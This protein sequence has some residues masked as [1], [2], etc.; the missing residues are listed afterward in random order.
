MSGIV[1]W[2]THWLSPRALEFLQRRQ[3]PPRVL[4][5]ADGAL[6]FEVN[7]S[8][9]TGSLP[10]G[11]SFFDAATRLEHIAQAGIAHQ[12]ISW[13]T[14]LGV[15]PVLTPVEAHELFGSYNDDLATLVRQHPQQLSGLAALTTSDIA[16]SAR[17]L[18]RAHNQLGLIGAVLP[19]GAFLNL[20]GARQLTPIFEVAQRLGS[21]IYLHTGLAHPSI[22]GQWAHPPACDSAKARWLLES[23]SQ[24]AAAWITLGLSDFL[25]AYPDV[26]VQLAM[27]GGVLPAL[28]GS[29]SES[30][31]PQTGVRK[32]YIDSAIIGTDPDTLALAIRH[33]GAERILFGSDYPLQSS[34]QVLQ[35]LRS[36]PRNGASLD[37]LLGSGQQLLDTLHA[38][39]SA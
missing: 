7:S 11:P 1:D 24:F 38:R 33:L 36:D 2:H 35:Q 16:W 32:L 18:E 12:V 14:T 15:D 9:L 21:H 4:R 17:E 3:Q 5:A 23:T 39:Q 28:L 37:T 25:D 34:V 27:L 26:S 31:A 6:S 13:P 19:A 8:V 22:P 30:D 10:I 20:E 29:L